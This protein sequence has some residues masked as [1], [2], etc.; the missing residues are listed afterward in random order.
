MSIPAIGF[1]F[2]LF[3]GITVP[4]TVVKSA[5]ISITPVNSY[6]NDMKKGS[7]KNKLNCIE[8]VNA[9]VNPVIRPSTH[10][11]I[12]TAKDSYK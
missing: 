3:N 10:D 8:R 12:V 5:S 2:T 1:L 4:I 9:I 7:S 6:G 11:V